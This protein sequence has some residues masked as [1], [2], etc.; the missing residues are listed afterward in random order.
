MKSLLLTTL[1][2]CSPALTSAQ[3]VPT[4]DTDGLTLLKQVS[5]RYTDARSYHIQS[6]SQTH[7][8]SEFEDTTQ[9]TLLTTAEAPGGRSYL[10]GHSNAGS[11][12]KVSDGKTVWIYHF[13]ENRYTVAPL[14]DRIDTRDNANG[15]DGAHGRQIRARDPCEYS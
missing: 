3:S 5:Q 15:G 4:K 6:A 10:E 12:L 7:M 1:I 14:A 11:A 9:K 8:V 2:A 13:N